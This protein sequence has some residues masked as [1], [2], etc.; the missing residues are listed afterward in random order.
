[1]HVTTAITSRGRCG[2]A[3]AKAAFTSASACGV[4]SRGSS[5][6]EWCMVGSERMYLLKVTI[7][8]KTERW[9]GCRALPKGGP[10]RWVREST[11]G[12]LTQG[13]GGA[14]PVALSIP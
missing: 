11:P 8:V 7:R 6:M 9:P 14:Q 1:M 2:R 4:E 13:W 12:M 10:G 5:W 3:A